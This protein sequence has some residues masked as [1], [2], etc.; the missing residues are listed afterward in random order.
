MFL[1]KVA[2]DYFNKGH[3]VSGVNPATESYILTIV[4]TGAP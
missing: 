3:V 2:Q 1:D 4:A